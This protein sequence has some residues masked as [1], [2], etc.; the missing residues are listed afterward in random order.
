[1][2]L[3]IYIPAIIYGYVAAGIVGLV[4]HANEPG[5]FTKDHDTGKKKSK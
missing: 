4:V 1:M 2:K 5:I 3:G